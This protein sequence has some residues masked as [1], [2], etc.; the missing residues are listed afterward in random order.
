[1]RHSYVMGGRWRMIGGASD[2]DRGIAAEIRQRY[3]FQN[4]NVHNPNVR[5]KIV[6]L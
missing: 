2:T 5:K 3:G 6:I 4:R 1:M